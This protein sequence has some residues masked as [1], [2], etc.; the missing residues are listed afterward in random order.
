MKKR[1]ISLLMCVVMLVTLL[2]TA[3]WA[4]EAQTDPGTANGNGDGAPSIVYSTGDTDPKQRRT[5]PIP[6][7]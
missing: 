4:Q 7:R 6:T 1:I 5:A 2:P 3:A